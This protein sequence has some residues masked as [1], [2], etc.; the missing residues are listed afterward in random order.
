MILI[1]MHVSVL[2]L[3]LSRYLNFET[4]WFVEY[5]EPAFSHAMPLVIRVPEMVEIAFRQGTTIKGTNQTASGCTCRLVCAF[6]AWI[7][8]IVGFLTIRLT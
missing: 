5:A 7:L 1:R 3:N 8:H 2:N 6:V 4:S